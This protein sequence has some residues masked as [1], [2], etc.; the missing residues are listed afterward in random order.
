MSENTG[1]PNPMFIRRESSTIRIS[2]D[3]NTLLLD[4][5]VVL[6]AIQQLQKENT[7]LR[8][9]RNQ[10]FADLKQADVMIEAIAGRC[11]TFD[12]LAEAR[13][14]IEEIK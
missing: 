6:T 13:S 10:F 7:Q 8:I 12:I 4:G 11:T 5:E 14:A 2:E 3:E 9:E 1:R